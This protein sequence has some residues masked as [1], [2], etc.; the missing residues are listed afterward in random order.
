MGCIVVADYCH[1][2]MYL[3]QGSKRPGHYILHSLRSSIRR[4]GS[5]IA[6]YWLHQVHKCLPQRNRHR[7][8]SCHLGQDIHSD[9]CHCQFRYCC[10]YFRKLQDCRQDYQ[11]CHKH[12]RS[13]SGSI[14]SLCP[15]LGQRSNYQEMDSSSP[16]ESSIDPFLDYTRIDVGRGHEAGE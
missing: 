13:L 12:N 2:H 9:C 5:D 3:P 1:G 7:H 8:I 10:R 15:L 14:Q 6:A 4:W 16:G 11:Y